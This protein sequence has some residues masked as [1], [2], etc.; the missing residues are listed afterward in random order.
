[1]FVVLVLDLIVDENPFETALSAK[2]I[3]TLKRK[4]KI[5]AANSATGILQLFRQ[6]IELCGLSQ[7]ED[8]RQHV[9]RLVSSS[10]ALELLRR[11]ATHNLD[12]LKVHVVEP[13]LQAGKPQYTSW[14]QLLVDNLLDDNDCNDNAEVDAH[15][16]V[17]RLLDLAN[18]FSIDLCKLKMQI[19]LNSESLEGGGGGGGGNATF[20]GGSGDVHSNTIARSFI[21]GIASASQDRRK[22]C[23]DLVTVLNKDCAGKIRA[24]VEELFLDWNSFLRT[25]QL[26]EQLDLPLAHDQATTGEALA[27]AFLS[28]IDATSTAAVVVGSQFIAS[29]LVERIAKLLQIVSSTHCDTDDDVLPEF[30]LAEFRCWLVLFLRLVI[31]HRPAFLQQQ[32]QQQ[33]PRGGLEQARMLA[34]LCCLLQQDVV[35]NDDAHFEM[36]LGVAASFADGLP[37]DIRLQLR[38]YVRGKRQVPMGAY[39]L[40]AALDGA[41]NLRARQQKG[42]L[43]EFA[44][45]PWER[46][47][48]PTPNI[49]E[50]DV[51]LSLALFKT[52]RF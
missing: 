28:V 38:R 41:E 24:D 29:T 26:I 39:I 52:R 13:L 27:R 32:Q 50:N 8:L 19:I 46:L 49:G 11:F 16:Q 35:R 1:M 23:T 15:V 17:A 10:S 42:E 37:D 9:L 36:V 7:D 18:D 25:R 31:L 6:V 4:R 48:E 44:V 21:R 33:Q 34:G 30:P 47:A 5:F 43:V 20:S 14:L 22:I 40:G 51:S 12:L 2:E 3:Y 45:K